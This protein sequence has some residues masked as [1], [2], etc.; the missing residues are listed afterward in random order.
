MASQVP[1]NWLSIHLARQC[2]NMILQCCIVT[3][4]QRGC[5]RKQPATIQSSGN[6]S[7]QCL[8][9]IFTCL[10]AMINWEQLIMNYVFAALEVPDS[11]WLSSHGSVSK[12]LHNI[13][14]R[15]KVFRQIHCNWLDSHESCNIV[16]SFAKINNLQKQPP[17]RPDH[18]QTEQLWIRIAAMN[19]RR[20]VVFYSYDC[21]HHYEMHQSGPWVAR[22]WSLTRSHG[23][24]CWCFCGRSQYETKGLGWCWDL[25]SLV[26]KW[27]KIYGTSVI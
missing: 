24:C 3:L 23:C 26:L 22:V 19:P 25:G 13:V 8:F 9:A 27:R 15:S 21:Y 17:Q 5:T 18:S 11:H 2:A 16:S 1:C 14:L 10:F 7:T 4:Q 12:Y 6:A 20:S